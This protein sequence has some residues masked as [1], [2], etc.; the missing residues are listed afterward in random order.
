M[1]SSQRLGIS[2]AFSLAVAASAARAADLPHSPLLEPNAKV[3]S[4]LE[5]PETAVKAES[6]TRQ[7]LDL[8]Q[9]KWT[10]AGFLPHLWELSWRNEGVWKMHEADVPPVPMQVPGSVQAALLAA[11]VISDWNQPFESR[12]SEWVENR[13]WICHA[14]IPDGWLKPGAEM[15][16]EC[17]GLDWAGW[18]M[19]NS[20]EVGRFRGTHTP[21]GF[22]VTKVLKPKGN[23]ID[24]IF[25]LPP[26]WL[27]QF[28]QTSKMTEWKARYNYTWDWVPRIVQ[29][30]IWD[31][32]R[33]VA[34]TGP[35]IADFQCAADADVK[36]GKG[37]LEMAADIAGK[38]NGT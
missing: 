30:G 26:R 13:H 10:V 36:S 38:P 20:K 15:R 27:G 34:T 5:G 8:S 9:L 3:I 22:D 1:F 24:I 2:L 33:L 14:A 11:G 19:I 18:V 31:D 6:A 21:Y 4:V 7:V 23:V 28:G 35:H 32:I 16:L 29:A 17:L 25:D 12:K 37:W